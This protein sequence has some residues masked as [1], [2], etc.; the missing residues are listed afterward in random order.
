MIIVR[1]K[2]TVEMENSIKGMLKRSLHEY[3]ERR[4]LPYG[5][6]ND[7]SVISESID[8]IASRVTFLLGNVKPSKFQQEM[9]KQSDELNDLVKKV[10]LEDALSKIKKAEL[11]GMLS[12]I[13][14][15]RKNA[16]SSK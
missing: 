1:D 6:I 8:N 9:W 5:F 2:R 15:G 3:A 12:R 14:K 13:R 16:K 4:G 11:D 7:S 10:E